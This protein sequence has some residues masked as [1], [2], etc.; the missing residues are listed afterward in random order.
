MQRCQSHMCSGGNAIKRSARAHGFTLVDVLVS[1]SVIAVLTAIMLPALSAVTKEVQR[2][3]CASNMRQLS[4]GLQ[5][6]AYDFDGMLPDSIFS[7]H[8]INNGMGSRNQ[9]DEPQPQFTPEDTIVIR[10]EI[11]T[12]SGTNARWDGIGNLFGDH[13]ITAPEVFYCPA[14]TGEHPLSRYEQVFSNSTGKIVSN[15]QYRV[16]AARQ[17]LSF[18]SS[19]F[20]LIANGLRTKSDYS[21][22]VGNNMGKA[23]GSVSWFDDPQ[24]SIYNSLPDNTS[25]KVEGEESPVPDAFEEMDDRP[26]NVTPGYNPGPRF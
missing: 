15:Y 22:I 11:V 18:L 20:T 12:R 7:G 8:S 17:R 16:Q 1:V 19:D 2:V 13:Y 9:D 3:Q 5:A 4:I 21:H 14:H 24:R 25:K 23:D 26:I 6:Y 10:P